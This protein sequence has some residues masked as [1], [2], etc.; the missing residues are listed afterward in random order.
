LINALRDKLL[1]H[2]VDDK[3]FQTDGPRNATEG[4]TVGYC[5]NA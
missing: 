4:V 2:R 3:L 5:G 1:S